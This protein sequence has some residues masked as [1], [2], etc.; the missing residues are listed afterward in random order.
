[1][2]S[3]N[4]GLR[5]AVSVH[6]VQGNG[7]HQDIKLRLGRQT[8]S[9]MSFSD[10]GMY[11]LTSVVMLFIDVLCHLIEIGVP[12]DHAGQFG[13]CKTTWSM[14]DMGCAYRRGSCFSLHAVPTGD[15]I[16]VLAYKLLF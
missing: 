5:K 1:M 14:H 2:A 8:M 6:T 13:F 12:A 10:Q 11:R 15:Y 16:A 9:S 3:R 4:A 7:E